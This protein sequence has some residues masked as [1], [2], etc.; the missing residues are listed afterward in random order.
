MRQALMVKQSKGKRTYTTWT[1]AQRQLEETIH[2]FEMSRKSEM[3]ES[4]ENKAN[5]LAL[6]HRHLLQIAQ[7]AMQSLKNIHHRISGN[8]NSKMKD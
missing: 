5:K 2:A 1:P 8:K 6:G 3:P 4:L 7:A